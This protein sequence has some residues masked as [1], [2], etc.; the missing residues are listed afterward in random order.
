[1]LWLC[2]NFLLKIIRVDKILLG[3]EEEKRKNSRLLLLYNTV[4]VLESRIINMLGMAYFTNFKVQKKKKKSYKNHKSL[5]PAT[6]HWTLTWVVVDQGWGDPSVGG[7][8]TLA[9]GEIGL[10]GGVLVLY[11]G[12]LGRHG[13]RHSHPGTLRLLG[14]TPQCL[15]LLVVQSLQPLGL[16]RIDAR[17]TVMGRRMEP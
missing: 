3:R 9:H 7:G 11:V 14:K 8:A 1:M 12:L 5:T 4:S 13:R 15:L 6:D 2:L 16:L 10:V 17:Q